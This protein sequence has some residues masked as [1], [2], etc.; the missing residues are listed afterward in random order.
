MKT[1]AVVS[2]NAC[3]VRPGMARKKFAGGLRKLLPPDV[4]NSRTNWSY[5]L[6]CRRD[7]CSQR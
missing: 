7:S 6:F 1:S 2:A 5:G 4:S 3:G